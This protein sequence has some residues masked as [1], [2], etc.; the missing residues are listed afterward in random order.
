MRRDAYPR[1]GGLCAPVGSPL[2]P[3]GGALHYHKGSRGI[4]DALCVETDV[5]S[6]HRD[7][8]MGSCLFVKRCVFV[9]TLIGTPVGTLIGTLH[10][11]KGAPSSP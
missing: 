6:T 8:L 1:W 11:R 3:H 7:A 5:I 2:S 9:G 10:K 4:I